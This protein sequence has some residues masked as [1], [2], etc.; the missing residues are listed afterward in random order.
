MLPLRVALWLLAYSLSCLPDVAG[1]SVTSHP[2]TPERREEVL[3]ALLLMRG[4]LVAPL[5][6]CHPCQ[7]LSDHPLVAAVTGGSL[8]MQ[9]RPRSLKCQVVGALRGL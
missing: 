2:H 7:V 1:R 3:N 4:V 6:I 8:V 9:L 5:L